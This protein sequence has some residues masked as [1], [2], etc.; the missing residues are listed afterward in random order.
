MEGE[1]VSEE[2]CEDDEEGFWKSFAMSAL[3]IVGLGVEAMDVAAFEAVVLEL[4]GDDKESLAGC[5]DDL[6][7]D[8]EA[9]VL[10]FTWFE[11]VA[12]T[13][14]KDFMTSVFTAGV[15]A[16]DEDSGAEASSIDPKTTDPGS[17]QDG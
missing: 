4:G 1:E 5:F 10:P 8:A 14:P 7:A 15:E 11:D 6:V 12:G 13:A 2:G 9:V 16:G 3:L 17:R